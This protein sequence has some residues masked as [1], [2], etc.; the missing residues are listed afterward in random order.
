L[1]N[2][3]NHARFRCTPPRELVAAIADT[4]K[5]GWG[6]KRGKGSDVVG[7]KRLHLKEVKT[8]VHKQRVTVEKTR[9]YLRR[10]W[11]HTSEAREI[12]E[13]TPF[14]ATPKTNKGKQ[15]VTMP[16]ISSAFNRS[17]PGRPKV[18]SQTW[19][20]D[21][22][23]EF[24]RTGLLDPFRLALALRVMHFG[25]LEDLRWSDRGRGDIAI[26]QDRSNRDR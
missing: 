10:S 18:G 23:R 5:W 9:T 3:L 21:E 24:G 2:G 6:A 15:I 16:V 19:V 1:L 12:K 25:V 13:V 8:N 26:G 17:R 7:D 20:C 11:G 4:S 14:K 22:Q